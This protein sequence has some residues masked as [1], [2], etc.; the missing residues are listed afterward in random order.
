MASA[1]EK[2]GVRLNRIE[3]VDIVPPQNILNAMALQKEADQQKR[4]AILQS[5][6]LQQAAINTAQ[7]EKQ[8]SI[9]RA[10]GDKQ[11]AILR[12]E[13]D[14]EAAIRLGEGRAGAIGATYTAIHQGNVT[15]ELLAV[16]QL[17]ALGRVAQSDNAKLVVPYETAGLM[18]AAQALRSVLAQ[19]PEAGVGPAHNGGRPSGSPPARS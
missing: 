1:T 17:E 14:K 6:G 12:A 7:G 5:E 10:E 3:I 16:L 2:W 8:A 4:A 18:G 11:S 19:V 9:L 15:P 13:G